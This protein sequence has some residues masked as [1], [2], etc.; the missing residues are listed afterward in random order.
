MYVNYFTLVPLKIEKFT[1]TE[2]D[3][4]I[5]GDVHGLKY[6]LYYGIDD[7]KNGYG[8][9]ETEKVFSENG[10]ISC[11]GTIKVN[12]AGKVVYRIK[13]FY[14]D[15][16]LYTAQF[17][18]YPLVVNSFGKKDDSN[19]FI[20]AKLEDLDYEYDIVFGFGSSN[21][22]FMS[23][24]KEGDVICVYGNMKGNV[25]RARHIVKKEEDKE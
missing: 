4:I 22:K 20:K 16:D 5:T 8:I 24:L 19:Y 7:A 21:D 6:T 18:L 3:Y 15:N 14:Y 1:K 23:K 13:H 11:Y 9:E 2:K 12:K 25:L 10:S 17:V